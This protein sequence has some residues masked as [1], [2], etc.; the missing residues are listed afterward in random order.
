MFPSKL[1]FPQDGANNAL[2]PIKGFFTP[3]QKLT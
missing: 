3:T 2:C 1:N